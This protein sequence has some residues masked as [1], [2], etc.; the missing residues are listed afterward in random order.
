MDTFL[1]SLLQSSSL[2]ALRQDEA[3]ARQGVM[4]HQTTAHLMDL[5]FTEKAVKMDLAESFAAQGLAHANIG[6]DAMGL[7]TAIHVPEKDKA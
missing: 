7:R 2:S 4:N 3:V 5:S 6:R 1:L